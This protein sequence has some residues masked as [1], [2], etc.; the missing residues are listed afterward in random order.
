MDAKK[1]V[2]I[3]VSWKDPESATG[4]SKISLTQVTITP[5]FK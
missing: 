5:K 3:D 2:S 4:L 1:L